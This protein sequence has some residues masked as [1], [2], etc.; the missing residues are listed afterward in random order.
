MK[1][2]KVVRRHLPFLGEGFLT[3][4]FLSFS[5]PYMFVF[6]LSCNFFPVLP[7]LSPLLPPSFPCYSSFFS[8]LPPFRPPSSFFPLYLFFPSFS[9]LLSPFLGCLL[10]SSVHSFL[11]FLPYFLPSY[12][13]PFLVCCHPFLFHFLPLPF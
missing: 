9:S 13:F 10:P 1:G 7:S 12:R 5:F 3:S 4:P 6:V 8:S 11:P 2:R